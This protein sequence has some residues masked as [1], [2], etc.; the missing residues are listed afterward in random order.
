MSK[1]ARKCA[2]LQLLLRARTGTIER[3]EMRQALCVMYGTTD[4]RRSDREVLEISLSC[5]HFMHRK[6][7]E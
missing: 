3:K 1:R 5:F 2:V 4:D 7:P 6:H